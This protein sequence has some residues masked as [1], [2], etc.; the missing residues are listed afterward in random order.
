VNNFIQD[1]NTLLS[2][3]ESSKIE[4]QNQL[5]ILYLKLVDYHQQNKVKINHS[6]MELICAKYLIEGGYEVDVEC[7][8]DGLSCD[9]YGTKGMGNLI[10]EIETGFIPPS[11][12]LDPLTYCNARIASKI[13]RYSGYT[14]KFC[15]GIP[16]HYI[17]PIPAELSTPP[18]YRKKE[19]ILTVK[20]L[21]DLY[22]H[23]PP[24]SEEE[25]KNARLHTIYIIDVDNAVV[26]E[27]DPDT[28]NEKVSLWKY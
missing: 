3:L 15:L 18:R 27:T 16:P 2:R 12:A 17:I 11:H 7:L 21:C 25:I 23:N 13:T 28:Y 4:V 19:D 20:K 1:L 9:L 8:L 5:K 14:N 10:V 26:H 24:V 22:Y 6:I